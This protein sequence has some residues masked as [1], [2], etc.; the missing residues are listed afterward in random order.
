MNNFPDFI[1]YAVTKK[2][3]VVDCGFGNEDLV[4]SALNNNAEF[5]KNEGYN[6]IPMTLENSPAEIG[7]VYDGEK[8]YFKET[9]NA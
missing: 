9:I 7:M 1:M 8:F 3:I 2:N 5:D 4:K 6:F